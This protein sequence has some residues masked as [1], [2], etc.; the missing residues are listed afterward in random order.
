MTPHE[1]L[2]QAKAMILRCGWVQVTFADAGGLCPIG[3]IHRVPQSA[4]RDQDTA[5]QLYAV[6]VGIDGECPWN[7]IGWNDAPG[8]TPEEVLE[9]FDRAIALAAETREAVTA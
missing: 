9:A 7:V 1:I 3:A 6:A 5:K 8:R 4:L 2:R